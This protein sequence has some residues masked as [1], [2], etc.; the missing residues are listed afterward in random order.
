MPASYERIVA[1]DGVFW[2]CVSESDPGT[3]RLFQER[4]ATEDGRARFHPI[5]HG[6]PAELPDT[7]YPYFLTT[8]RVLAHYQSGT[9]TRRVAELRRAEPEAFVEVHPETA[10]GLGIAQGDRVRLTTRRGHAEMNAR[11]TSD[12]RLDTL[13]VP[14]HWA[15]PASANALTH[16]ALDPVSRIPE[17]KVCA[18]RVEK[19]PAASI[20]RGRSSAVALLH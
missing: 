2:P 19:I 1:Q 5:E 17:F 20:A 4:F 18:V 3:P 7:S 9:Q 10:R 14:F 11:L 13:F 16:A 12:A 8:G 15:A 6:T